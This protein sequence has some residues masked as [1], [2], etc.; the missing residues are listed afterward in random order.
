MELNANSILA[1]LPRGD[2]GRSCTSEGATWGRRAPEL[3][4]WAWERLVN[5]TDV[6]GGYV[7][8]DQRGKVYTRDD[9]REQVLGKTLT[10]PARGDRGKVFL[11]EAHLVRHFRARGAGDVV[12]LHTTGPENTSRWGGVELDHHGQGGNSPEANRAAA[13]AWYGE[14]RGR[15]FRPLLTDSN[16]DGGYHLR[17]LL[18]EPAPTPRVFAFLK[19][20]VA[21]HAAHRLSAAP[22]TFPKQPAVTEGGRGQYGNWLRLP[23][24]H[25]TREHWSRVWDGA[26]WLEGEKAVE[27]LLALPGDPPDLV[28]PYLGDGLAGRVAAYLARLPNLGEGQGRDDVAYHFACFLVRDLRLPDET[29]LA[30]LGRWDAG[31]RPP[32]GAARLWEIL[33]NAHAYG[34]QAYGSGLG[35]QG[36]RARGAAG[37]GP[38]PWPDPIPF[39]SEPKVPPFPLDVLPGVL[40]EWVEAVAEATQTPPDLAAMLALPVCGAGLA[41]K[42]RVLVRPGWAEPTNLFTATALPPGERKSAVFAE[43]LAPV[44]AAE[45]REQERAQPAIAE[46]GSERRDLELRLKR[47]EAQAAR[48]EG[49]ERDDL[50]EEARRLSRELAAHRVP[51]PPQLWCE[52]ITPEKL[53]GLLAAQG[54]RMLQASAEGTAFEIV[55]GRYSEAANFDVYLKGHAGDP[56]RVNRVGRGPEAVDLP[57]LSVALAVQ[58]DVIRGL[59]EDGTLRRR[60][61]LARW[62]YALPASKVGRREVAPPAVPENVRDGYN[63]L[64]S[65]L[66]WIPGNTGEDGRPAPHWLRFSADA[67]ELLGEFERWLEPRLAEGEELFPLAG[68]ANKLAGAVA[69]VAGILHMVCHTD[70]ETPWQS[71][72]NSQTVAAAVRLGRDYLLPHARAAFAVMGADTEAAR[73]RRLWEVIRR[74]SVNSVNSVDGGAPVCVS[75]RDLHRWGAGRSRRRRRWTQPSPGSSTCTIC[76]PSR[77]PGPPGAG[78]RAPPTR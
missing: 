74:R 2:N 47:A 35:G 64:V 34:R 13:L 24:R 26:R 50:R 27:F 11:T 67:D 69:R 71:P 40:G 70:A 39:T 16:G 60:G 49:A 14:L 41:R 76:A 1:G 37:S 4:R 31:N 23:G 72:I 46:A 20:L 44:Q 53:A 57:A 8:E 32:K 78:T 18:T 7:A 5:R 45:V 58:P 36:Q 75:R 3:A 61:F 65:A 21:D 38:P 25:H 54:G 68:W 30:W 51:E 73:A 12:G 48:A 42:F 28:L 22:E 56:L 63:R 9:G 55:K 17:F 6:W 43:A 33:A 29:A 77:G 66:W 59:A 19:W 15:G 62:L 52:D 10:R